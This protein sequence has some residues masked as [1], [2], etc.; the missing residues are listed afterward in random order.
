M[1]ALIEQ[2]DDICYQHRFQEKVLLVDSHPLGDQIAQAYINAG[3]QA[4]NLK[5]KTVRDLANEMVELKHDQE[6]QILDNAVGVHFIYNILKQLSDTNQLSYFKAIEVTPSFSNNIYQTITHLRQAGYFSENIKSEAFISSEKAHDLAQIMTKYQAILSTYKLLDQATVLEKATDLSQQN[7]GAIFILQSNLSLTQLEHEFLERLL[8]GTIFKLTLPRLFGIPTP[9]HEDLRSIGWSTP[10]LFSYLYQLEN[11]TEN[12][13]LSLFTAKTEEIELKHI[14]EQIKQSNSYLDKSVIYYTK[15]EPYVTT[16]FQLSQKYQIP[17]TYGDGVSILFS[18]PGKLV[19]GLIRWMK[20]QYSVPIFIELLNEGLIELPEG[21]VS[22]TKISKLL[23]DAQVGWNQSRYLSQLKLVTN[24]FEQRIAESTNDNKQTGYYQQQFNDA[25][26]LHQWFFK[27][28]KQLPAVE[29]K[30]NYHELLKGISHMLTN[31]CK[32]V[33]ALDESAHTAM[34]EQIDLILP[35]ADEQL[36][37]FDAFEKVSDLLLS[38]RVNQS[39]PKAGHL[40]LCSYKKGVYSNRHRV[41]I[42]GLDNRSFP[43]TPSEDPLLLDEERSKLS[44]YLPILQEAGKKNL[45]MMLQVLAHTSGP[46]SIS[47]CSFDINDNRTVSPSHLFLQ[48]YRMATNNPNSEFKDL[49]QLTVP[50]TPTDTFEEKDYWNR[51][52]EQDASQRLS[53]ELIQSYPNLIHGQIAEQARKEA[54]FTSFDGQ[55]TIDTSEYDPRQNKERRMTAGKLE[56]LATC[57]YAYFLE[58]VLQLKPI[59]EMT[60]DP[61]T[62]M[63]PATRGSLLHSV[64]EFFYK[65]LNGEKPS[66]SIH[67]DTIINVAKEKIEEQKEIQPPPSQRVFEREVEDIYKCCHIFLKEEEEYGQDYDAQQFEYAFGIKG[68]TPAI[69]T[70]PSNQTIHVSGKIDRVDRSTAGH[71]H[72]IDYKTGSTY[73]YHEAEPFKGGRQLQHFIYALAIEQHLQLESGSV[74]ESSYFFPSSKGLGERYVRKQ[75]EQMRI[76]GQD[77][78]EKLVDVIKHGHFTMTD[79]V[80]DCKFCDF[81]TVCRREFYPEDTLGT[82]QL[83]Q[84]AEGVRKFKGVRAYE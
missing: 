31:H 60:Y 12:P 38:L 50:L 75:D 42:V 70:L 2:L 83:D 72:I 33:S 82:K 4:I 30:M 68:N 7:S 3:H 32:T 8:P 77:M 58:E 62:W 23:R 69:I 80:N 25:T 53:Q 27:L 34:I 78:L 66:Y 74:M 36:N 49:K 17:V 65:G 10:T 55:V 26:W 39:G 37:I 14:F 43:G 19:S 41:F 56:K 28:F 5:I 40:H 54:V 6:Y 73:N 29:G 47:Y 9:E 24:K 1:K 11:K 64:F 52:L 79:D 67:K 84:Q 16:T 18:R 71:L 81:K 20:G 61:Y 46:V 44:G 63:D 76:N 51:I 15:S 57:P 59:D 35:Y 13:D 48:G 22:K 21:S 45:Y